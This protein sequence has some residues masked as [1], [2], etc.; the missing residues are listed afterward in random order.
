MKS[1][2]LQSPAKLNL[3]LKVV[4]QRPD[5]YHNL[6]T[7]F[8]RIDLCDEIKFILTDNGQISIS[9]QDK[10]VPCGPKNLIYKA[11]QLLQKD[12]KVKKGVKVI[13]DKRIP[14]AAGLGGGSSNGATALLALNK[15]WNLRLKP[16]KLVEYGRQLGSDVP[17]FLY[18]C[19]WALGTS[20]GDDIKPLRLKTK[21]WHCLITPRLKVYSS[22]VFKALGLKAAKAPCNNISNNKIRPGSVATNLL[23]KKELDVNILLRALRKNDF[24]SAGSLLFNGLEPAIVKIYPQLAKVKENLKR[25]DSLGVSFSGSGPSVFCMTES[26]FQ[27]EKIRKTLSRRYQQIFTVRTY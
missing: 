13:L 22:Q 19:S 26:R 6:I 15:L 12:G 21:L 2:V 14:V 3:F 4:N 16:E 23:T 20:R 8:E 17:F 24:L 18:D 11:A 25:F 10:D 1:I 5:G 9:C 7:L 27:S